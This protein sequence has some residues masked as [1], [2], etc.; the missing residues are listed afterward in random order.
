MIFPIFQVFWIL[1][2]VC[3]GLV[4]FQELSHLPPSHIALFAVAI[5][6]ITI[7][8]YFLAKHEMQQVFVDASEKFESK[9]LSKDRIE[10]PL[11]VLLPVVSRD[12]RYAWSLLGPE[13]A[14][15]SSGIHVR[16]SM[17]RSSISLSTSPARRGIEMTETTSVQAA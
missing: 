12:V 15:L 7:G 5:A 10:T 1:F 17:S 8:V 9:E 16:S 13:T 4:F 14:I 2:G 3:G 6:L 11:P